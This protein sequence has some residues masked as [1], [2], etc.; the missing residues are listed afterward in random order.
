MSLVVSV[1]DLAH[2]DDV[3]GVEVGDVVLQVPGKALAVHALPQLDSRCHFAEVSL[4]ARPFI[5]DAP[6][7]FPHIK[8]FTSCNV[9][10]TCAI[11][12]PSKLNK[13]KQVI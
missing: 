13:G 9:L 12:K 11:N 7:P 2:P 8:H 6:P 4:V 10:Q 3:V 5:Y 1:L